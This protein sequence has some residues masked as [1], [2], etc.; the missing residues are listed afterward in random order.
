MAAWE[1]QFRAVAAHPNTVAKLSGLHCAGAEFSAPALGRVWDIAL[2]AFGPQRLMFGGD[3]PV[4]LLGGSYQCTVD[5]MATLI[6]AL[7]P[8]E[9]H[10]I[11]AATSHRTYGR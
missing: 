11:W 5:V 6:D 7:S 3:W 1:R 8:A 9:A 10:A 2:D 4:S